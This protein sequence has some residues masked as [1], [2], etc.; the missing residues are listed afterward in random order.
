MSKISLI[1]GGKPDN[2]YEQLFCN[3]CDDFRLFTVWL[4]GDEVI[5]YCANC[6]TAQVP[7]E[8]SDG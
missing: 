5:L 1:D 4:N 2:G 3:R 8:E 6:A 7:R